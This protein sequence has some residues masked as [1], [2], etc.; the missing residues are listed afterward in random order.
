MKDETKAAKLAALFGLEAPKPPTEEEKRN[1]DSVSREAEAVIAYFDGPARF[2][3][4]MCRICDQVFAVNRGNIAFCSDKC[5]GVHIREVVGIEWWDPNLRTPEDRWSPQTGGKEPLIVP[6]TAL[7]L[8]H[9]LH[10]ELNQA[11][12]LAV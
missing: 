3:E 2:T 10:P 7:T 4:R 5:R 8:L 9:E 11:D 1:A 12:E 6:P